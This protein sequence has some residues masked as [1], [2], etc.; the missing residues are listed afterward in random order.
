M[1]DYELKEFRPKRFAKIL[2]GKVVGVASSGEVFCHFARE[3][4]HD[5]EAGVIEASLAFSGVAGV[6]FVLNLPILI[7][8]LAALV[9]VLSMI[10]S[11]TFTWYFIL[12]RIPTTATKYLQFLNK[13]YISR[14]H[15]IPSNLF[16][17]WIVL[18]YPVIL[19]NF[20]TDR[21]SSTQEEIEFAYLSLL[22]S[23]LSLYAL[24][25]IIGLGNIG[26]FSTTR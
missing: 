18:N 3:R 11:S 5:V 16:V 17:Y 22:V 13:R 24:A 12:G 26:L 7:K 25:M 23:V 9:F 1:H 4:Y 6:I 15:K 21:T 10:T 2:D 14:G 8:I 20:M 19:I